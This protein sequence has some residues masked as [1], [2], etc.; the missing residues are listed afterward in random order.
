M[1]DPNNHNA[2]N[3][4]KYNAMPS[5]DLIQLLRSDI[6]APDGQGLSTDD[7]L[8]I[9]DILA[10]RE[11]SSDNGSVR[12]VQDAWDS[13]Q[14]NY[15]DLEETCR[16]TKTANHSRPWLRHIIAAAAILVLIIFIPLTAR[17]LNWKEIFKTIANWTSNV[18]YFSTDDPSDSTSYNPPS[19][20]NNEALNQAFADIS[21]KFS[22]IPTWIPDGFTLDNIHKSENSNKQEHIIRYVKNDQSIK[23]IITS[24]L[25]NAPVMLEKNNRLI[26]IYQESGIDY[27]IFDNSNQIEVTWVHDSYQHIISGNITIDDVKKMI[28]SIPKG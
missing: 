6:E 28:Q 19:D 3:F 25:D 4:S 10:E 7:L 12:P 24:F 23:I 26:E 27:Y 16:T 14:Q 8:Q 11:R 2:Q 9:T 18:F 13:F 5:E 1:L 15:L 17:A 20:S 22:A 21:E